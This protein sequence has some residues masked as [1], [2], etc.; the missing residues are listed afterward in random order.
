MLFLHDEQGKIFLWGWRHPET[1]ITEYMFIYNN[2]KPNR[3]TTPMKLLSPKEVA[4]ITGLPY[5][6]ALALVKSTNHIQIDNR[7]YVSET[8]L[9]AFLNPD[10]ALK[11]TTI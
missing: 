10:T 2:I 4:D 5:I 8:V 1:E 7:Y 11:I 3:R 6:K 9:K